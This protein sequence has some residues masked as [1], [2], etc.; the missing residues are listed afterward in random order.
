MLQG[1][2]DDFDLPEVL[3]LLASSKKT[4]RLELARPAGPGMVLFRDGDVIYAETDL[5]AS[6]L[7]QKLVRAGTIT[8]DQ[9]RAALDEQASTGERLGDVLARTGAASDDELQ[10]ALSAQVA[11]AIYELL[12]WDTGEFAW[13]PPAEGVAAEGVG[14]SVEDLIADAARRRGEVEL[15]RQAIPSVEAVCR[16]AAGPPEGVGEI[17]ITPTEWRVLVLVDGHRTVSGIAAA[18]DA[19]TEETMRILYGLLTQGLIEVE[20]PS[21]AQE[22]G[23]GPEEPPSALTPAP[24]GPST[25]GDLDVPEEWFD[26]PRG[27]AQRPSPAPAEEEPVAAEDLPALDR[28][29]AVRELAGLFQEPQGRSGTPAPPATPVSSP[30]EEGPTEATERGRFARFTRRPKD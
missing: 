2:L 24:V 7:G 10:R 23:P 13:A 18:T 1:T 15:V 6:R 29:A 5:A 19:D 25:S 22:P 8:E 12:C 27:A 28:A 14:L 9:L 16:M 11:D 21:E 4:G 30:P 17:S 20:V 3:R 26:D